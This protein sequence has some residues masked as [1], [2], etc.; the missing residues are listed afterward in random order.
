METKLPYIYIAKAIPPFIF[1]S[2][3]NKTNEQPPPSPPPY[4][5]KK[6]KNSKKKSGKT[7]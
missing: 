2:P 4:E 3:Q 6:K 5:E 1:L 7:K